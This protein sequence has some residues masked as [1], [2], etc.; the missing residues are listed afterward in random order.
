MKESKHNTKC[1]RCG[2]HLLVLTFMWHC[3]ACDALWEAVKKSLTAE[4]K[5]ENKRDK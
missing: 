2:S 1:P 3:T 5:Y 4:N